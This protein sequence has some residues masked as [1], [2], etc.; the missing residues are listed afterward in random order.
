MLGLRFFTRDSG[1]GLGI[2]SRHPRSSPTWYWAVSWQPAKADFARHWFK[3]NLAKNCIGPHQ[4]HHNLHLLKLGSLCL[5][6]Q[7]YHK[8]AARHARGL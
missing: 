2:V 7:G 4:R 5:S 1:G 8:E 3:L 6:T